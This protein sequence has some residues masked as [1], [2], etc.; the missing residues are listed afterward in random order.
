[1]PLGIEGEERVREAYGENYD[2]LLTLKKKYDPK[3]VFQLNQN[4]NPR[5]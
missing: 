4:I 2:R 3:N 1:M 5:T